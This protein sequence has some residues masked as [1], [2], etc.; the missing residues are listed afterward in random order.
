MTRLYTGAKKHGTGPVRLA[1]SMFDE[2][3]AALP[4]IFEKFALLVFVAPGRDKYNRR[5]P[6]CTQRMKLWGDIL[7]GYGPGT[8]QAVFFRRAVKLSVEDVPHIL[9]KLGPLSA[10]KM[11]PALNS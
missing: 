11:G 3:A 2:I 9:L 10:I 5:N 8:S 7:K 1:S 4:K 6:C